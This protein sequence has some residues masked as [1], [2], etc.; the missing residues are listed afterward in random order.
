MGGIVNP[1]TVNASEKSPSYFSSIENGHHVFLVDFDVAVEVAE[2]SGTNAAAGLSVASF[3]KLGAGGNSASSNST[4][5]RIAFKV[6]LALPI[7]MQSQAKLNDDI[8]KSHR[9]LNFRS[10]FGES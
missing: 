3:V 7:D 1:A 8:E 10:Q 6:P 9:P 4:S 2:S 5:N